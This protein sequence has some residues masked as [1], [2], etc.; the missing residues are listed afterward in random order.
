M[1]HDHRD[2]HDG[3]HHVDAEEPLEHRGARVEAHP[4]VDEQRGHDGH[5]GQERSRGRAVA[6]FEI[7]GRVEMRLLK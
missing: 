7:L 5:E 1:D 6:A 4:D 2:D 3:R